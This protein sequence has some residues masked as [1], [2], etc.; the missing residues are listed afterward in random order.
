VV[1]LVFSQI[2]SLILNYWLSL[3][4]NLQ[5]MLFYLTVAFISVAALHIPIEMFLDETGN[6]IFPLREAKLTRSFA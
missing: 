6:L 4:G 1:G 5:G 2:C 3:C